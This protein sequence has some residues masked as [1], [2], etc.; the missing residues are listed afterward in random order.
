MRNNSRVKKTEVYKKNAG[1]PKVFAG[2]VLVLL[3]TGMTALSVLAEPVIEKVYAYPGYPVVWY[4]KGI[5]GEL[6]AGGQEA[7]VTAVVGNTACDAEVLNIRD[8][9][10]VHF[11]TVIMLDNSASISAA[12]RTKAKDLISR[13]IQNHADREEF[14]IYTF[15]RELTQV[16]AGTDYGSLI[17]AV[18][19]ITFQDQDAYLTDC[20][21][22]VVDSLAQ[23]QS[24]NYNRIILISDGVDDNPGGNTLIDLSDRLKD[25]ATSCTVYTIGCVWQSD[26]KGM[27]NL[28]KI[29]QVGGGVSFVLDETEDLS[30]ITSVIASDYNAKAIAIDVPLEE[31]DGSDKTIRVS[32]STTA[33]Q[34]ELSR[35]VSIPQ[36]TQEE[37]ELLQKWE[38]EAEEA[39][40]KINAAEQ[41]ISAIHD[42]VT[43]A[44]EEAVTA[45]EEAL[46]EIGDDEDLLGILKDRLGTEFEDT[47][48]REYVAAAREELD[49]ILSHAGEIAAAKEAIEAI[50]DPV[51]A[52]DAA[53]VSAAETALQALNGDQELLSKLREQ[54]GGSYSGKDPETIVREAREACDAAV[55]L[56]AENDKKVAAAASAIRA[57]PDPVT[58][59]ASDEI[60]AAE[61]ALDEIREDEA[62][63]QQ[64]EEELGKDPAET[65]EKAREDLEDLVNI[66]PDIEP[67]TPTAT[68]E[69]EPESF[70]EQY[71]YF[72]IGGAAAV[73]LLVIL[74]AVLLLR[75]KKTPEWEEYGSMPQ[76]D[77]LD[78]LVNYGKTVADEAFRN[79]RKD[80][81]TPGSG[82]AAV[83]LGHEPTIAEF[84]GGDSEKTVGL[85]GEE[86]SANYGMII[87]L[88]DTKD[89]G[90]RYQ[91]RLQDEI[92]IG[93]DSLCS[94]V[95]SNDRTI[96]GNH[97]RLMQMNGQVLAE[98][99][100]SRNGTSING[101]RIAGA[102][103][104]HSGDELKLGSTRLKVEIQ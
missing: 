5:E 79:D 50:P 88:T 102:A 78:D 104:L 17:A 55:E 94:I 4:V 3:L 31:K 2:I 71:K 75:R 83:D 15:S 16:G 9:Q 58:E 76:Q 89:P 90:K 33:G 95:I 97:C 45:A 62:L 73:L 26:T 29:A 37:E 39:Y 74:A 32:L 92:M 93:R 14:V 68:P 12:N 99:L 21:V 51:T 46:E 57:I 25:D 56:K 28:Q 80:S 30:Q 77:Q 64:L 42:P 87:I 60:E 72:I 13:I 84:P 36:R 38:E 103:P 96:S 19:N 7:Q 47:D 34:V 67:V 59:K 65:V 85:W 66:G 1:L 54:L 41:A 69:P 91:A 43:A 8:W 23:D 40:R 49:A 48:P 52:E 98:D 82:G 10:D 18:N 100:N 86:A 63:M 70:F 20:V 11:K 22:S 35:K 27:K 6:S 61:E 24:Y 53:A 44:D 81:F 101:S